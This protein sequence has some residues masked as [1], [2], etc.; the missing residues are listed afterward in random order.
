MKE[1]DAQ[2]FNGFVYNLLSTSVL[3]TKLAMI[4][5]QENALKLSFVLDK[6]RL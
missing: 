3:I 2:M 5:Y 1:C 4:E 6:N